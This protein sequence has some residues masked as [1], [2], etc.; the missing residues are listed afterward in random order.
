MLYMISY[1]L[2]KPG[3]SYDPLDQRITAL[4]G[5]RI[6]L[7][8]W[9]IPYLGTLMTPPPT[10]NQLWTDLRR[11]V[12]QNDRLMVN[13]L[14]QNMEWSSAKLLVSDIEMR[15]LMGFARA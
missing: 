11:Y 6:L 9:V 8:Q 2:M 10:A 4:N 3:Q 1:D 13:E 5:K 14:T 7:S 12:D 15:R